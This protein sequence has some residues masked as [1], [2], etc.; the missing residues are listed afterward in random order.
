MFAR[1]SASLTA[2]GPMLVMRILAMGVGTWAEADVARAAA[3]ARRRR[4]SAK[5]R[6]S[7]GVWERGGVEAWESAAVSTLERFNA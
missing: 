6:W 1:T 2:A 7:V 4:R 5:G 3:K